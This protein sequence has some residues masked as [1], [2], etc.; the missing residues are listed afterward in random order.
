MF[1]SLRIGA[2][3][4]ILHKHEPRLEQGE[5]LFISNP[6]PQFGQSFTTGILTPPPTTVDINIKVEGK[7]KPIE[8]KQLPASQSIADYGNGMVISE[9]KEAISNEIVA[10]KT[11]SIRILDSVD[12]HKSMIQKCD[13]LLEDLNP[14]LRKE[15]ERG[16][17][18][19]SLTA[20]VGGLETTINRIEELLGQALN[21]KTKEK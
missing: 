12:N 6:V 7:E 16:R 15:A 14:Q 2:P 21:T 13:T 10:V 20:R 18:L 4:Y 11:N 9:S 19:E 1:Q 17:E 8:I 3:L 5:I